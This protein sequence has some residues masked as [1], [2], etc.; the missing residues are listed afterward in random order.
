MS[1]K[2]FFH[3]QQPKED[4]REFLELIIF[5]IGVFWLSESSG[6]STE[7]LDELDLLI[8]QDLDIAGTNQAD[9]RATKRPCKSCSFNS[10]GI[11]QS[12]V[13]CTNSSFCASQ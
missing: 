1:P 12:L 5:L 2:K 6:L 8:A 4:Y 13:R 3:T 7:Q 9:S 10:I 11:F